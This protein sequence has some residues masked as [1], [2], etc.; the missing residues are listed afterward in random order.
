MPDLTSWFLL[1]FAIATMLMVALSVP[2]MRGKIKPNMIYGVR[3]PK[4]LSD[5]RIWYRSNA[6]GGRLLFRTGLIQ[7]VAIV[8]LYAVPTLRANFAA[9][10]VAC[11][12][13]FLVG[14]LLASVLILRNIRAQ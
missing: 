9:Y 13:V 1:F 2:L 6:Y 4:T 12:T 7:L 14:I 10:N 8:A 5:E 3:T 11:A